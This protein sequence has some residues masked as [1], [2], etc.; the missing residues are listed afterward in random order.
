MVRKR[1]HNMIG[2]GRPKI[3]GPVLVDLT[4]ILFTDCFKNVSR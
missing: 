4:A 3:A 2:M 1:V